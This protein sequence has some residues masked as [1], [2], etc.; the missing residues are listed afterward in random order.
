MKNFISEGEMM[1]YQNGGTARAS[2]DVV[3]LPFGCGVCSVDIAAN[4][5]GSVAVDGV[6]KLKKE[7]SLAITQGDLVYWD[8]TAKEIDK[9]NTNSKIGYA[10]KGALAADTTVE[11]KLVPTVG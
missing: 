11:V 6:F 1:E 7:A 8:D 9:T 3:V 10:H 4:G 5:L 2:G